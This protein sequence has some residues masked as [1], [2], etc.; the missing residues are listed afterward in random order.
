MWVLLSFL[1]C[2][3]CPSLCWW[4]NFGVLWENNSCVPPH[5]NNVKMWPHHWILLAEGWSW[6]LVEIPGSS[7]HF[8]HPPSFLWDERGPRRGLSTL[9]CPGVASPQAPRA[10]WVPPKPS[11]APGAFGQ[12]KMRFWSVCA[13]QDWTGWSLWVPSHSGHSIIPRGIRI[14]TILSQK[15]P[16]L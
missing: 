12:H 5:P 1:D 7:L 2:K 13:G 16:T 9:L 6:C 8:L 3:S 14:P 15:N 11:R 4:K 10:F